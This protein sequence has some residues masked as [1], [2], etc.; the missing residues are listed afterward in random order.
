MLHKKSKP[1]QELDTGNVILLEHQSTLDLIYN[2]IF[3]NE[4]RKYN[5]KFKV[6]GNGGTMLVNLRSKI[7]GYDQTMWFSN[8]EI[9]K[10]VSLKDMTKLYRVI[11]GGNNESFIVY[12]KEVGIPNI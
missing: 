1:E 4:V 8:K 5:I 11:Y 2:K 6:K 3:T 10:I 9:T 12:R 7:P